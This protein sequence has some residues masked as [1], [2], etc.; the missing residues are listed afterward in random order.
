MESD[1]NKFIGPVS[2]ER[3]MNGKIPL[4]V[5]K[6]RYSYNCYLGDNYLKDNANK[7]IMAK[8]LE[9][10]LKH[11]PKDCI[12]MP[13]EIYSRVIY[14]RNFGENYLKVYLD[15]I[16]KPKHITI[17]NNLIIYDPFGVGKDKLS[18]KLLRR[19]EKDKPKDYSPIDGSA[20]FLTYISFID[21]KINA[22]NHDFC[23]LFWT[24]IGQD[25]TGKLLKNPNYK[26]KAKKLLRLIHGMPVAEAENK[27]NL[28]WEKNLNSLLI[29]GNGPIF[30]IYRKTQPFS[31]YNA[32]IYGGKPFEAISRII[33]PILIK[34]FRKKEGP[35]VI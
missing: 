32:W 24:G 35:L 18:E 10:F 21:G 14:N 22:K 33:K 12:L 15:L 2:L 25:N 5:C 19:I 3:T 27:L 1:K 23:K 26:E 28:I 16:E 11:V 31:L 34:P 20:I 6:N 9:T 13:S 29:T 7:I 17:T 4:L 8:N 30:Y